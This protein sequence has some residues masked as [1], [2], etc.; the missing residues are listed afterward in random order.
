MQ[1]IEN[2]FL[3]LVQPSDRF[4]NAIPLS[5]AQK[6]WTRSLLLG[7]YMG[8]TTSLALMRPE[9]EAR[10]SVL[11]F[12]QFTRCQQRHI[13]YQSKKHKLV[14]SKLYTKTPYLVLNTYVKRSPGVC[15]SKQPMGV[16]KSKYIFRRRYFLRPDI[17]NIVL[18]YCFQPY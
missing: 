17:Y 1:K 3:F 6:K 5:S 13:L 16:C 15:R 14:S 9:S 11:L 12:T 10:M 2:M 7:F 8:K 4:G 18:W